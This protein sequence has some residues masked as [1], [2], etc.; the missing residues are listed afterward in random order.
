M[1]QTLRGTRKDSSTHTRA[2]SSFSSVSLGNRG[3]FPPLIYIVAV[4]MQVVVVSGKEEESW[5]G[6]AYRS[7]PGMLGVVYH[8]R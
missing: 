7:S 4:L 2:S 8:V 6:G 1:R 5:G 3:V